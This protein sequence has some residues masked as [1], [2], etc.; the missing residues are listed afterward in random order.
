MFSIASRERSLHHFP[1]ESD[2]LVLAFY[3]SGLLF[4][5]L[6]HLTQGYTNVLG[7]WIH[8]QALEDLDHAEERAR[9][10]GGVTLLS[11]AESTGDENTNLYIR[12]VNEGRSGDLLEPSDLLDILE[13]FGEEG[14]RSYLMGIIEGEA[15]A[16]EDEEDEDDE[17]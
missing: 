7:Y 3:S 11:M 1:V 9:N 13:V 6:L 12:G 14:V 2:P 8:E 15:D 10:A 4:C 17:D 16:A 5:S